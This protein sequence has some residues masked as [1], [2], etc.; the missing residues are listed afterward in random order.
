MK[1]A[2]ISTWK[3]SWNGC[4][5][6]A[7]L[8]RNGGSSADAV[9]LGIQDVEDNPAFRSVG[10][11]GLPDE[12]GRVLLDGAFMDGDS[13]RFGAVA[14]IEG[15]RSPIAIARSLVPCEFN[16]FLVGKGAEKYAEEHGFEKR[17]NLTE[18]SRRIWEEKKGKSQSLFA[19]DG[20]DTVCYAVLDQNHTMSAG[21]STSGLFL[22]K[23][24]R[25]GDSPVA[26]SGFYSD[27]KIGTACATGVGEEIMKGVLSYNALRNLKAG[28][29]AME[30]ASTAVYEL[31]E[32]LKQRNGK[33][34][35]M[36]LILLDSNG[37]FGVGTNIRFPFVYA[38]EECEPTLFLAEPSES[39]C[40]V[41]PV[42]DRDALD[43]D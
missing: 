34:N 15:F 31:I 39:G 21:V 6:A 10:Y 22:K 7:E 29:P 23:S 12:D 14:S 30:A 35:A 25:V 36:S 24:G 3:M 8:L 19:Y 16:N 9:I 4:N 11:G 1:W 32:T 2:V 41:H 17:D 28:M 40:T 27:S 37:N 5:K 18:E 26:G 33:A 38:S 43:I 20:H 13:L 42:E